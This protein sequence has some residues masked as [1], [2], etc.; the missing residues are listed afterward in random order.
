MLD[1]NAQISEKT[2]SAV[3][4]A[5]EFFIPLGELVDFEKEK[6]RLNKEKQNIL[7]EIARAEGKLNNPGFVSKAPANLVAAEKEKLEKNKQMLSSLEAR[8]AELG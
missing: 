3:C 5:G 4:G 2:V 1:K 8:I 6:A 7:G